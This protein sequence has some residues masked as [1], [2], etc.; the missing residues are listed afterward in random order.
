MTEF[1]PK[2]RFFSQNWPISPGFEL[3]C[4][5][6]AHF[7]WILANLHGFGPFCLDL[8]PKGDEALRMGQ[9]G[10]Y[11]RTDGR[12]DSPCVLQDFVPFGAAAQKKKTTGRFISIKEENNALDEERMN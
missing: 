1:R 7:A 2:F 4:Q 12:T 3:F 11:G 8:G 10:T 6:L 9:G 5:E